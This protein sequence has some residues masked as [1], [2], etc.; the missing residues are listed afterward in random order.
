M[1]RR[2]IGRFLPETG[3]E[4]ILPSFQIHVNMTTRRLRSFITNWSV[5]ARSYYLQWMKHFIRYFQIT[6]QSNVTI[7]CLFFHPP[8]HIRQQIYFERFRRQDHDTGNPRLEDVPDRL[9]IAHPETDVLFKRI[10]RRQWNIRTAPI[11]KIMAWVSR[12]STR[13]IRERYSQCFEI[14]QIPSYSFPHSFPSSRN[15]FSDPIP[16][17]TI[18]WFL[19]NCTTNPIGSLPYPL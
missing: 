4:D 12:R 13:C 6:I 1:T 14:K 10:T 5:K 9:L 3:Y 8:L 18:Q 15:F 11:N 17:K 16:W 19:V 2:R 7:L